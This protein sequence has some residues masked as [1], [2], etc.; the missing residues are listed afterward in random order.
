MKFRLFL[1][2]TFLCPIVFAQ[3]TNNYLPIDKERIPKKELIQ[4]LQ[5]KLKLDLSTINSKYKNYVKDAY[6]DKF[7]MVHAYIDSSYYYFDDTLNIYF[8][9]VYKNIQTT[10]PELNLEKT[11]LFVS[12]ETYPNAYCIGEGTLV[13]NVGLLRYLTNE[14]Q[15]AFVICHELAHLE[16]NHVFNDLNKRLE[17]MFSKNMQ[18]E[19]KKIKLSN[20]NTYSKTKALAKNFTFDVRR[21]GREHESEADSI[22]IQYLIK[23]NYNPYE[24]IAALAILDSIDQEKYQD[25]IDLKQFFNFS[26]YPFKD[27]WTIDDQAN[28]MKGKEELTEAEKDSLKTHPNCKKRVKDATAYLNKL[29]PEHKNNFVQPKGLFDKLVAYSDFECIENRIKF[30]NVN[31]AFYLTL[32]LLREYPNNKYLHQTVMRCFNTISDGLKNH[33]LNNYI[34]LPSP[35]DEKDY[36]VV[37]CFLNNIRSSEVARIMQEYKKKFIP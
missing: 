17:L 35:F 24:A 5:D 4:N 37:N 25:S 16:K 3:I 28:F 12:R 1:I 33:N 18:E 26:D 22:G 9:Q 20:E 15:I 2:Y 29:Q 14:S 27:S 21:H 7:D 30:R 13:F 19:L 32:K 36:K 31:G 10:N 8:Q 34:E 11:H 6:K 23:T